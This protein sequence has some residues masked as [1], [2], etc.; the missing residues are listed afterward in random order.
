MSGQ[1]SILVDELDQSQ[2]NSTKT[3]WKK[4]LKIDDKYL[5]MAFASA[6]FETMHDDCEYELFHVIL[7]ND[8]NNQQQFG[9]WANGILSETMSCDTFLRKKRLLNYYDK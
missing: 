8:E 3:R 4:L 5:L 2:I 6:D 1:H 7:E 9:I